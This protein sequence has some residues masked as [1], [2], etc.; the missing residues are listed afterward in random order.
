MIEWRSDGLPLLLAELLS[1]LVQRLVEK[2]ASNAR[3]FV[4]Y[5][6]VPQSAKTKYIAPDGALGGPS[7]DELRR[8]PLD[9][10]RVFIR[11]TR[12]CTGFID[13]PKK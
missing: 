3:L 12:R 13:R 11:K 9:K 1:I 4:L 7:L 2:P 5:E 8:Q 6:P 10:R